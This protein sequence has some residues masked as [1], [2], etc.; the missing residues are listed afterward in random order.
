MSLAKKLSTV[1]AV[2]SNTG[3]TTCQWIESLPADDQQAIQQWVKDGLSISQLHEIC[4]AYEDN[5][6]PVTDSAFRN[7]LRR[8]PKP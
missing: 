6:L 5:P 8:H 4:S 3:C 2:K 7:H 1:Q